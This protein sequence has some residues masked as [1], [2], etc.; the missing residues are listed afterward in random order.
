MNRIKFYIAR[1]SFNH[2][3]TISAFDSVSA[4]IEA[5]KILSKDIISLTARQ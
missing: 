2:V 5:K 3:A 1:D 4:L